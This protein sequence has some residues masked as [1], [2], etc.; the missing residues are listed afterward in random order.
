[1]LGALLSGY[2]NHKKK[3]SVHYTETFRL[4]LVVYSIEHTYVKP[5]LQHAKRIPRTWYYGHPDME[6]PYDS[7]VNNC[8][9]HR[10]LIYCKI[11]IIELISPV[12]AGK[13]VI[14][15]FEIRL[16]LPEVYNISANFQEHSHTF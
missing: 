4:A 16:G 10:L 12:C 8:F 1:V 15:R 7:M 11:E 3:H 13:Q 2:N 5:I 6:V 14:L 9:E